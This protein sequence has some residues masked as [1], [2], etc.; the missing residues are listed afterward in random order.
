MAGL[1]KGLMVEGCT[2]GP[3]LQPFPSP[4]LGHFAV[5][6]AERG[7]RHI[8]FYCASQILNFYKLKVCDNPV[9]SKSVAAILPIAFAHCMSLSHFDN[10]RNVSNFSIVLIFVMGSV[11]HDLWCDDCKKI[12]TC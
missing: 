2:N 8:L 1:R 5:P 7:Y 12:R 6:F 3:D 4:L 9:L 10:S 11:I